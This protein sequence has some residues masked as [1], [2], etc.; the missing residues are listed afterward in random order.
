MSG[1]G[2]GGVEGGGRDGVG[3]AGGG[4]C[5]GGDGGLAGGA[6]GGGRGGGGGGGESRQASHEEQPSYAQRTS[7]EQHS[8]WSP[9]Q[10]LL[11]RHHGSQ[12]MVRRCWTRRVLLQIRSSG[13]FKVIQV[14]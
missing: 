14:C 11:S 6:V 10:A 3:A 1:G 4:G 8:L 12:A 9:P 13:I 5:V 2:R 7:H